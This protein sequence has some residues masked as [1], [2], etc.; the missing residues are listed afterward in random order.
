MR[1][2]DEVEFVSEDGVAKAQDMPWGLD[3]I[4]QRDFPLDQNV[5]T[6]SKYSKFFSILHVF[7]HTSL[8]QSISRLI[9]RS[10]C[11]FVTVY[12][13]LGEIVFIIHGSR[14][15]THFFFEQNLFETR[16]V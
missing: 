10:A 4:N 6:S 5:Q 7:K 11:L 3:R 13:T 16:S 12:I 2:L 14:G 1:N 9:G 15:K 8:N